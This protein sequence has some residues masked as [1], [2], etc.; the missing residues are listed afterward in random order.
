MHNLFTTPTNIV[1]MNK[2]LEQAYLQTN[3]GSTHEN[4]EIEREWMGAMAAQQPISVGSRRSSVSSVSS[5]PSDPTSLVS[6]PASSRPSSQ[7]QYASLAKSSTTKKNYV[8]VR[9]RRSQRKSTRR[10]R[11]H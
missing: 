4:W 8:V 9:R 6:S 10:N 1:A 5:V 7:N 2:Q 11:K 3:P